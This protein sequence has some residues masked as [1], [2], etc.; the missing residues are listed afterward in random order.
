MPPKKGS[1]KAAAKKTTNK[2]VDELPEQDTNGTSQNANAT[3]MDI[4]P[5]LDFKAYQMNLI[6]GCS[7]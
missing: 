7:H 6:V 1:K 3:A 4:T 5:T 2:T